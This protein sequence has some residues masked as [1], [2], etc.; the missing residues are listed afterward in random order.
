MTDTAQPVT[1]PPR[2]RARMPLAPGDAEALIAGIDRGVSLPTE[3]YTDPDL[4]AAELEGLHRRGMAL[5]RARR[6]APRSR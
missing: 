3:W 5:R 6:D 4:F 1:I 2:S